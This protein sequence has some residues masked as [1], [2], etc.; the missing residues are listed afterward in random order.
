VGSRSNDV[1]NLSHVFSSDDTLIFCEANPK[2]LR[3]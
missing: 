3:D 2:N 1:I